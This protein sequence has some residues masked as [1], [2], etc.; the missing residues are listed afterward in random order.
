MSAVAWKPLTEV[1]SRAA[2]TV[3]DCVV[4]DNL[5]VDEWRLRDNVRAALQMGHA[6][7]PIGW[8]A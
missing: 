1:R 2:R 8:T 3:A 4:R 5:I 6:P 7:L